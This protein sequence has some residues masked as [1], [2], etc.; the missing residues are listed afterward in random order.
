MNT[1]LG[2]KFRPKKSISE[3]YDTVIN[4][5]VIEISGSTLGQNTLKTHHLGQHMGKDWN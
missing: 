4:N 5:I 3:I 2:D 1:I